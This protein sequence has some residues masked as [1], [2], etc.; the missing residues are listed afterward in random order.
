[1]VTSRQSR[2]CH[3]YADLGLAGPFGSQR[4]RAGP[5]PDC[6]LERQPG[7][8]L[9]CRPIGINITE[10]NESGRVGSAK[11]GGWSLSLGRLCSTTP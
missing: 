3:A 4:S 5:G 10:L 8:T 6:V 2:N 1:M 9:S 7:T 11:L